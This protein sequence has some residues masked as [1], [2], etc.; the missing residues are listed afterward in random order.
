[1]RVKVTFLK[2]KIKHISPFPN[3]TTQSIDI[4]SKASCWHREVEENF[5]KHSCG[6]ILEQ[7]RSL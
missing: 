1:M 2:K 7:I 3:S 4:L 5:G 6:Q